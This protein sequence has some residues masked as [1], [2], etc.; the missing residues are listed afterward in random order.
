MIA[1]VKS[2]R[3]TLTFKI[4]ALLAIALLPIGSISVYQTY[5]LVQEGELKERSNLM[6]LT[7]EGADKEIAFIRN[8]LGIA[9]TLSAMAPLLADDSTRCSSYLGDLVVQRAA[10]SFVG[11]VSAQGTVQCAS[12][13]EGADLSETALFRQMKANPERTISVG[14]DNQTSD[15]S[16][17]H[18]ADPVIQAGRFNGFV[19]VS[20][21]HEKLTPA[22]SAPSAQQPIDLITF[23][24]AGVVLTTDDGAATVTDKIPAGHS[25]ATLAKSGRWAFAGRTEAGEQRI[26]AVAPIVEDQ[27]F[28]LG[29]WDQTDAFVDGW[30]ITTSLMFP[31]AMWLAGLGVAFFSV[32]AMV[33]R[34][35]RNLRA[36]MLMFMRNRKL[37]PVEDRD[38]LAIEL[39]EIND[40]WKRMAESVLKDEQELQEALHEKTVLLKEV[41]HRVKNNLQLIASILNIKMRKARSEEEK[42]TLRG[43]QQRVMSIARV[44]QKLYETSSQE[45]VRA[46]EL[47]SAILEQILSSGHSGGGTLDVQES[48][49]PVIL[50]PDQ[51]VPLS[52][53]VSELVTNAIKHMG[54]DDASAG[55][56]SV[57]FK[58]LDEESAVFEIWNSISEDAK[59][60]PTTRDGG[61]GEKLIRAFVQ[62]IDG[63]L[64]ES[65][66]DS[67]FK[68]VL[69]F[70]LAAFQEA[71]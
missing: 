22:S 26:F 9:E 19:F 60:L 59:D 33:I 41:H 43:I 25:L 48:Y 42:E 36:R 71:A 39:L 7:V 53:A 34:P 66:Q 68:V 61:L 8:A 17:I 47:I 70:P 63:S 31:A 3:Q 18:V 38:S 4:A 65:V 24:A 58:K 44:H 35:T 11:Y 56:L 69:R 30:N 57:K 62:Q 21:L 28:A 49:E 50:Y 20:L 45:R 10:V 37:I 55:T 51:A 14:T 15:Q 27:V 1:I 52:L 2:W 46:D 5:L 64:S 54:T 32:Q 23:N 13:D 40:T 67:C 6:A 16:V 12:S 29:S